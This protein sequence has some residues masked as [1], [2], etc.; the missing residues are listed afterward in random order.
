ML[1]A[2]ELYGFKSFPDRTRFDFPPGITVVVGP[3]GS[4]KSNIVDAI[5]WVLGEQ[6]AKSLRGKEMA[7]VIFKGSGGPSGR[8][9]ANSAEATIYM[10]NRNRR[11]R[12]DMDE[13][14]VTRRV[15]RSGEGEYMI[16]G[17]PCR[18]KDIRNLFRGTGIGVDSYSLIEQGKIDQMLQASAKDR[19]AMFE[20]AAGISRF[21][22]KKVETERRLA[23]VETNLVRLAD[24]VEE[25]EGSYKK[26]QN[27]ASKASKYKEYSD[28]LKSLR[29]F[30]GQKDWRD[31]SKTLDDILE[32]KQSVKSSLEERQVKLSELEKEST[33]L[34]SKLSGYSSSLAELQQSLGSFTQLIAETQSQLSITSTRMED[35]DTQ[36]RQFRELLDQLTTKI[37]ENQRSQETESVDLQAAEQKLDRLRTD[38]G[39]SDQD[40]SETDQQLAE[41]R[42]S[43]DTQRKKR[44][45]NLQ[46]TSQLGKEV[47]GIDSQIETYSLTQDRLKK[48]LAEIGSALISGNKRLEFANQAQSE[49]QA[50]AEQKDGN[51]KAARE[52]L[53]QL[54]ATLNEQKTALDHFHR[55]QVGSN[56]RAE[57]IEELESQQAGVDAGVKNLIKKSQ[58]SSPGI[59]QGV[60]GLV[61]DLVKVNVEH[62]KL[63][64]LALG[65]RAQH[66]VVKDEAIAKAVAASQIRLNG[67]VGLV[68]LNAKQEDI[69]QR[70][71]HDQTGVVGRLDQLVQAK[72][73]HHSVIRHL[74]GRS[75]LVKSMQVALDLRPLIN[76]PQTRLITLEGEIIE[77]DGTVI[78][79]SRAASTGIVSRRSELRALHRR[80]HE[81]KQQIDE[82]EQT[83]ARLADQVNEQEDSIEDL[84]GEHSE[85]SAKLNE[86]RTAAS[87]L[88]NEIGQFLTQQGA[89][90][91]DFDES[92]KAL[93]Q[94]RQD[95]D[96]NRIRLKEIEDNTRQLDS[97][98]AA[99]EE[100][101]QSL[102]NQ[103]KQLQ[104]QVTSNKVSF[105]RQETTVSEIQSRLE[106]IDSQLTES[107]SN[108]QSTRSQIAS[109]LWSKRQANQNVVQHQSQLSEFDS[110]KATVEQQLA[111]L[112]SERQQADEKRRTNAQELAQ[113]RDQLRTNQDE[114]HDFLMREKDLSMQRGQLAER[115]FEDYDI[116]IEKLDEEQAEIDEGREQIDEEINDLRKKLSNIGPVNI[117]SLEELD[118]VEERY[119]LLSE[120]YQDLVDAKQTLEKI[121]HR[122]NND[123]RRLFVETLEQIRNNFQTL[124]RQTF[125][126]GK[127]DLLIEEG[128]DVLEA[129][130]DITATPPGK[131]EFNNS[132][133][134]GGEKAMTAV[135]LL[136]AI[137]KFRPSPFCILDEVDAPFDEANVGRFIE[138]L[139]SFLGWTKFIIVTH[140]KKTMTA[141]T[142]LYGVTM[143][144]SGVSK[145]VSVRFE[146]VNEK[147]E[148]S[149]EAV[150]RSTKT[151][152]DERG[153]A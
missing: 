49:L 38:L 30:V 109:L 20:E 7:D 77:S 117:D 12:L 4:G 52:K 120:Q 146:D 142:T 138:T 151:D 10:D 78:C 46:T 108:F 121:I 83:V 2:L 37:S 24:I 88:E 140:S 36:N 84:L 71:L 34:D 42:E 33:Q 13:I 132:L 67:R 113:L 6:S 133:L 14:S 130:V 5:K 125:G 60:V 3:N 141:A 111:T 97:S 94:A 91:F 29:T 15:Y 31:F 100:Q 69:P 9:A 128:V 21:K 35:Q 53:D 17:E 28:R 118:D 86:S 144:E 61:A 26:I 85:I 58:E 62:A 106:M 40:L 149:D 129:G 32:K 147:G 124:F 57:L 135:S 102:E 153:V 79:G 23:R 48:S 66:V 59:Y 45:E 81:L 98:I 152:P 41:L 27:Q 72:T 11:L 139:R 110:E 22:A 127:A 73:E 145:R 112:N 75:W 43:L 136:M 105:A 1:N 25:V 119:Q 16:N 95:S 96:A 63:I 80:L 89:N 19:R 126:G 47:S 50:Q 122:I 134:S 131:P 8:K 116:D 54:K 93:E 70:E 104:Q 99:G 55:E 137:F 74:L 90:Q 143:Q 115:L 76:S 18:L 103:Q 51:L 87:V 123:S 82:K 107:Q 68:P 148:I 114:L 101:L 56:Q 64:D 92:V 150:E 65:D 39:K 44:V